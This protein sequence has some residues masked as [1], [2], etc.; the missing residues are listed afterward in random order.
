MR[1]NY[2][3]RRQVMLVST[4]FVLVLCAAAIAVGVTWGAGT[5]DAAP[6]SSGTPVQNLS[7]TGTGHN[8]YKIDLDEG[9]QLGLHGFCSAVDGAVAIDLY[10][11]GTLDI[12]GSAGAATSTLVA[13]GGPPFSVDQ[14]YT[15][16]VGAAGTYYLD[17]DYSGV[18]TP[19]QYV[20]TPVVVGVNVT[21][22]PEGAYFYAKMRGGNPDPQQITVT[23][24]GWGA[25]PTVNWRLTNIPTW[26]TIEPS[27][28]TAPGSTTMTIS[29]DVSG[30]TSAISTEVAIGVDVDQPVIPA[31]LKDRVSIAGGP[32]PPAPGN[33]IPVSLDLRYQPTMRPFSATWVRTHWVSPLLQ[34]LVRMAGSVVCT[35]LA[36]DPI[37]ASQ[38]VAGGRV[39]F[40]ARPAPDG[41]WQVVGETI[42]AADGSFA[43]TISVPRSSIVKAKFMGNAYSGHVYSPYSDTAP[44]FTPKALLGTPA[45]AS[46]TVRRGRVFTMSGYVFPGHTGYYPVRLYAYRYESGR[47]VL[48]K[49]N[50]YG[51]RTLY[52]ANWSKWAVS[53]TLP[54]TGRWRVRAVHG[55]GLLSDI[56]HART[57]SA[58]RYLTVR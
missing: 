50:I 49:S 57:Y 24:D 16:P 13:V 11:P 47:W 32:L 5:S 41:D 53:T 2:R 48:R 35:P 25:A 44:K 30:F 12:T 26:L 38:L 14:T 27:S 3:D 43:G 4:V 34:P 7:F 29:V 17:V 22:S 52:S 6:L 33:V 46:T 1:F 21:V 28:G 51:H 37:T 42:T 55:G 10:A 19:G 20:L 18:S 58:Y 36:G 9:D 31:S 23:I 56:D 15:V 39:Y 40:F 8:V 45:V 54:S